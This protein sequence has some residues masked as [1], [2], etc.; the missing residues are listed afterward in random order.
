MQWSKN[1]NSREFLPIVSR[2][3][4]VSR[5]WKREI[6][7]GFEISDDRPWGSAFDYH[8][9]LANRDLVQEGRAAWF[10]LEMINI[11]T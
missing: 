2:S 11:K 5:D 6:R 1:Q 8:A 7:V 9:C 3:C 10:T 4:V